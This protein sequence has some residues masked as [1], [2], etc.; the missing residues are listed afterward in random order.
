MHASPEDIDAAVRY[1]FG[2][3]Y[4]AAGPFRQKELAG[5][6]VH[7]AA[8]RST[9]P[10]LATNPTPSRT[11]NEMVA[12]GRLGVKTGRGF[13]EWTPETAARERA[14][15][16]RI[17]Q[18]ALHL[19]MPDRDGVPGAE[20]RGELGSERAAHGRQGTATKSEPSSNH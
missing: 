14:R 15:Y 1:G 12:A 8:S 10:V 13:W 6:D 3:R 17:L 18:A 11:L 7:L 16:E 19:L 4:L 5:L 2:F 20:R 9:Y